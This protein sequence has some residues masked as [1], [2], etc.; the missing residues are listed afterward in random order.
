MTPD[1]E[2]EKVL[3]QATQL[4]G[5]HFDHFQILTS[6]NEEGQTFGKNSGGGN[7]YARLQMARTFIER[8]V[9]QERANELRQII[10]P[11]D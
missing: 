10:E 2:K 9:S 3:E 8:D 11:K 7:W 6:W 5:D 4:L 1:Q